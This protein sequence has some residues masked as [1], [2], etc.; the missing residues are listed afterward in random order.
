ME[1][2]CFLPFENHLKRLTTR[3][4]RAKCDEG[5]GRKKMEN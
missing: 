3:E 2:I 1:K 5:K 4:R